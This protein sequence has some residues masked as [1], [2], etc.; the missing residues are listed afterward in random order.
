ML[1]IAGLGAAYGSIEENIL[2]AALQDGEAQPATAARP[3]IDIASGSLPCGKIGPVSMSRLVIGGNLIGGWA[4]SRDL[5]YV[6]RLFKAYNTE[7]K[8]FE[9]LEIAQEC[10]INAIQ[11]D[12]HAWE[13]IV[14]Y[15]KSHKTQ[16]Q[17][18]L[19]ISLDNDKS[20]MKTQIHK[21]VD[22]GAT[23]LYPHGGMV[24]SHMM[25]GGKIDL[26]GD[27]VELIK[28]AGVPAG[29]GSHSLEVPIACEKNKINP[30]YYVKT[31]HIDRYWSATPKEHR[32]EYDWMRAKPDDHDSNNHNMFCNNSVETA[33]FME[34]VNK[35][36]VAF[37]VMAAGALHP[38]I[39]FSSAYRAGADFI[40]AGMFDF[41][42]EQDVKLAI[43]AIGKNKNR[44][45]PWHG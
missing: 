27:A 11:I 39:A 13:P 22:L 41:Q 14:R 26:I 18:I 7:A 8:V 28:A 21:L 32:K 6:S 24:D 15:N 12:P 25:N 23:M 17:T 36:W 3:K 1:G 19:C 34:K 40:L 9:T 10:G 29:V 2:Q 16:M 37:K 33:A 20:K 35:P 31:Y 42:V 5:A 30:D 38:Q 43:E 45:R 44:K 4:H